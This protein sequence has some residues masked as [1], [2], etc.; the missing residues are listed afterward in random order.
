MPVG[1]CRKASTLTKKPYRCF[2]LDYGRLNIPS[3]SAD[4][5]FVKLLWHPVEHEPEEFVPGR[6][7]PPHDPAVAQIGEHIQFSSAGRAAAGIA[8]GYVI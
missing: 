8:G 5:H 7:G 6:L 3:P 4:L 2:R 1:I